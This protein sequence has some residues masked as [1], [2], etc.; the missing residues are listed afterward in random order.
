M[1]TPT[2]GYLGEEL[3]KPSKGEISMKVNLGCLYVE[4]L[5]EES[6]RLIIVMSADGNIVIFI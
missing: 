1:K 5:S 3:P 6:T 2:E 4:S